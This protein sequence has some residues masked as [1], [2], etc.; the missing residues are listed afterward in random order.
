MF[1]ELLNLFVRKFRMFCLALNDHCEEILTLSH[2]MCFSNTY[3]Q[4]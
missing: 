2:L 3:I 1:N 4:E